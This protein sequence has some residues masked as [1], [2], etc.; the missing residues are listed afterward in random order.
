MARRTTIPG[1]TRRP[2]HS[3]YTHR[4]GLLRP[5]I[6][7]G[8]IA[9]VGTVGREVR[10]CGR[11]SPNRRTN[12]APSP[13]PVAG[14]ASHSDLSAAP[15]KMAPAGRA[16]AIRVF[17]FK[18]PEGV[19]GTPSGALIRA[20]KSGSVCPI[21]NRTRRVVELATGLRNPLQT[22]TSGRSWEPA[23]L[24][25]VET[26]AHAQRGDK[27]GESG[28]RALSSSWGRFSF[29]SRRAAFPAWQAKCS[30]ENK[31][32]PRRDGSVAF[33]PPILTT[34]ASRVPCRFRNP[35]NPAT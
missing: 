23:A 22:S 13:Y 18:Q 31:H 6:F 9:G 30:P 35:R 29:R 19:V 8:G 15:I 2:L 14:G 21:V 28:G 20:G 10:C 12:D 1:D 26:I 7:L 11:P 5:G 32:V 3:G 16:E 25:R 33:V 17:L 27:P 24:P 4:D 34:A